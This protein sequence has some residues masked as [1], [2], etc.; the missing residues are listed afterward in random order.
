MLA[1]IGVAC[2]LVAAVAMTRAL[3]SLLFEMNPLDPA[4]YAAVSIGLVGPAV[5]ATYIP[6]RR[7]SAVDPLEAVRAE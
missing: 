2:G 1:I 3:R 6:A 5:V 7:A 4:T